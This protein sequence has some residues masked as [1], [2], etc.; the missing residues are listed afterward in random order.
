MIAV[1]GAGI[2]GSLIAREINKYVEDVF[3]FEAK[4]G[5]GTGVTK[6]NSGIIHGGYDDDP[7]SL[8]AELCYKGN[9]L[10]DEVTQELSVDVKRVGS[11]VV[12]LNEDE[13]KAIDELEERAIKNRVKEY[14]ILD[15]T[16][17]LEME[18]NLNKD[19]LKSFYCP[20][21]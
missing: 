18:P 20:I 15:K 16:D 1:I 10:Y 13:L 3:I 21:A 9:K 6:G 14:E 12:A 5:I 17:L 4:N 19:A 2:V 11:H 7:G 8:R